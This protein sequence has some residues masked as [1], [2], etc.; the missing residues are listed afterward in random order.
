MQFRLEGSV[1][2]LVQG[3]VTCQQVDAIVNAANKFLNPGG[4]VDAAIHGH[5]GPTIV[6]ETRR[7]YPDG[8]PTGQ[9][10]ITGAGKLPS[11]FVIHAVGPRWKGGTKGE[12]AL[13]ASAYRH[14]LDLAASN[15]CRSLAFPSISTGIYGYPVTRAARTAVSTVVE[16][17]EERRAPEL[18]RFVLFDAATYRAYAGAL[19]ENAGVSGSGTSRGPRSSE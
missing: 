10:V 7:R 16:F 8:C 17:L 1:L 4:G 12:P 14:C 18:V 19:S 3:D 15:D 6:E 13:L 5:G 11:R 9:A 2:E